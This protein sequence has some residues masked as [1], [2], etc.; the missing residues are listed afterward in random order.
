MKPYSM[1]LSSPKVRATSSMTAVSGITTSFPMGSQGHFSFKSLATMSVP[2]VVAP[3]ANTS[4]RP[5]P[6][7]P[8]PKRAARIGSMGWKS[9]RRFSPSM[10][11]LLT[12]MAYRLL[13]SRWPPIFFQPMRNSGTFISAEAAPTV[14]AGNQ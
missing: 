5:T 14:R 10:A 1:A 11:A 13:T 2:P 4:P 8:P 12:T 6:M 3:W 9:K 7:T